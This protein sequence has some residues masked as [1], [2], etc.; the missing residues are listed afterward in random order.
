MFIGSSNLRSSHGSLCHWPCRSI[1]VVALSLA[2]SEPGLKILACHTVEEQFWVRLIWICLPTMNPNIAK[3]WSSPRVILLL[4]LETTIR[5]SNYANKY[6]VQW[7]SCLI[8]Q[9]RTSHMCL[10]N[11][12]TTTTDLK[13]ISKNL[14]KPKIHNDFWSYSPE[15]IHEHLG[16]S[17][18]VVPNSHG[19]SKDEKN[20]E[21]LAGIRGPNCCIP[22]HWRYCR[23]HLATTQSSPTVVGLGLGIPG[24]EGHILWRNSL[25]CTNEG[26]INCWSAAQVTTRKKLTNLYS[27]RLLNERILKLRPPGFSG[28][29]SVGVS[30][31]FEG[32]NGHKCWKIVGL[33]T[34]LLLS[35]QFFETNKWRQPRNQSITSGWAVFLIWWRIYVTIASKQ[36]QYTF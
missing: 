15:N 34:P 25:Q 33:L 12:S 36:V 7:W 27:F 2:T 1:A 14:F 6:P 24:F 35:C 9:R 10:E 16:R 32:T 21:F 8:H 18:A 20:D 26:M 5:N 23:T 17:D 29:V 30:W 28:G 22:E 13:L 31:S 3:H 11:I 4:M 19:N